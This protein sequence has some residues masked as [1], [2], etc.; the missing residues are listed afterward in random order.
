MSET[1]AHGHLGLS[2]AGQMRSLPSR[3]SQRTG[4][5]NSPPSRGSP[6]QVNMSETLPDSYKVGN[7]DA[8]HST[9]PAL[10]LPVPRRPERASA[11]ARSVSPGPALMHGVHE[12][13]GMLPP[14][15]SASMEASL[16]GSLPLAGNQSNQRAPD[17]PQNLRARG[18][19]KAPEG[20]RSIHQS[21]GG[22]L[23]SSALPVP[24][25]DYVNITHVT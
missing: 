12:L 22:I 15:N 9:Q 3:P 7:S 1:A 2:C 18:L 24:H 14:S 11:C 8:S 19:L 13:S 20:S 25:A 16:T 5:S 17:A 10:N 6:A 23:F 21:P 4:R